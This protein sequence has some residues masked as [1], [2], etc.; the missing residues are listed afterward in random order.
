MPF[1]NA[2]RD[3]V[4]ERSLSIRRRRAKLPSEERKETPQCRLRLT[5]AHIA[6]RVISDSGLDGFDA[7]QEVSG[8]VVVAELFGRSVVG[9]E[10]WTYRASSLAC[11]SESDGSKGKDASD[12]KELGEMHGRSISW[13]ILRFDWWRWSMIWRSN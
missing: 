5:R 4:V 6:V 12:R 3:N 7:V 1:L 10:R 8:N 2:L 11:G 9:N 13:V